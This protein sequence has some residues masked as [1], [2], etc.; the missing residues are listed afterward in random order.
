MRYRK[1]KRRGCYEL[2]WSHPRLFAKREQHRPQRDS[3]V[4]ELDCQRQV[5]AK[6]AAA[7]GERLRALELGIRFM[8]TTMEPHTGLHV[9]ERRGGHPRPHSGML[10]SPARP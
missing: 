3:R 10:S 6:D 7:Q 4:C 1:W 8:K 9:R 2:T 5:A